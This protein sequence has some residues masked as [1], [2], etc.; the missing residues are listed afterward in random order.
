M[1]LN[2]IHI[3]IYLYNYGTAE[4]KFDPHVYVSCGYL[5]GYK[6]NLQVRCEYI[7][8]YTLWNSRHIRNA[9]ESLR[10]TPNHSSRVLERVIVCEN[11]E[12]LDQ[13]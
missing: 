4:L 1:P 7:H 5:Q 6:D 13:I 2:A 10:C 3:C 9:H 8:E 12:T 11:F